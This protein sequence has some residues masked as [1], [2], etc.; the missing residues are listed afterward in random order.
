MHVKR[1]LAIRVILPAA[2]S[3]TSSA[4]GAQSLSS[5][6]TLAVLEREAAQD[7]DARYDATQRKLSNA[8]PGRTLVQGATR[9]RLEYR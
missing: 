4:P 6:D 1:A 7:V 9:I 3:V 2:L 5:S 8:W